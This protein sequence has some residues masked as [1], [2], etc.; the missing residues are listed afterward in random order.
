MLQHIELEE[1]PFAKRLRAT[2]LLNN[3]EKKLCNFQLTNHLS[4]SIF[5]KTYVTDDDDAIFKLT[6]CRRKAER[7]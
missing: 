1:S 4:C 2:I 5:T 7:R 6:G 3:F